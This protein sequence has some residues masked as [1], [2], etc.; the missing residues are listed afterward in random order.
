MNAT[1]RKLDPSVARQDVATVV[2]TGDALEV[3]SPNGRYHARRAES[4]LLA[5]E[6]GDEVLVAFIPGRTPYVLAVLERDA[7]APAR[8]EVEGDLALHAKKGRVSVASARGLDFA[9]EGDANLV[10]SELRV[11]A[12]RGTVA[13]AQLAYVGEAIVAEVTRGTLVAK[14]LETLADRAIQRLKR[15]YRFVDELDQLRA[16]RVD[17]VAESTLSLRAENALVTA[18]KLVKLDGDQIH[19]G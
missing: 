19:V 11:H 2:A 13:L 12:G 7:R 9:T 18:E 10:A 1:A 16:Q 15:A 6:V 8:L 14:T 4:C 3:A 5:P 17:L